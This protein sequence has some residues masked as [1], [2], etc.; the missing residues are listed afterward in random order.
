[1]DDPWTASIS[2]TVSKEQQSKLG[3]AD[4]TGLDTAGD[5]WVLVG[6]GAAVDKELVADGW[7]GLLQLQIIMSGQKHTNRR[8][9]F[10]SFSLLTAMRT[11]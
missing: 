1:M 8:V 3:T 4:W 7:A 10:T 6:A 9:V 5:C 11:A 2:S